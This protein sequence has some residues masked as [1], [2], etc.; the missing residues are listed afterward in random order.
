MIEMGKA[1]LGTGAM[2][3]LWPVVI[4]GIFVLTGVPL[5]DTIAEAVGNAMLALSAVFFALGGA[6]VALGLVF[7]VVRR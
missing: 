7:D 1:A 5:V 2:F 3:L 6:L 4:A